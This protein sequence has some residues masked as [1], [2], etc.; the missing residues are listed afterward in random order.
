MWIQRVVRE[1]YGMQT[2][3]W[4]PDYLN[5]EFF[6]QID[7]YFNFSL[8]RNALILELLQR[9]KIFKRDVKV[10]K[11]KGKNRKLY[12]DKLV[13]LTIILLLVYWLL[14]YD[15][16]WSFAFIFVYFGRGFLTE[17]VTRGTKIIFPFLLK[18]WFLLLIM[19]LSFLKMNWILKFRKF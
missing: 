11:R 2:S 19:A 7:V 14:L 15:R 12:N 17:C 1:F 8:G 16:N 9:L 10:K 3:R 13:I 5:T 4:I 18:F 6:W